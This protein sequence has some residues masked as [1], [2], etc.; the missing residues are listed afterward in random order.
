MDTIPLVILKKIFAHLPR[1]TLE[2]VI[3]NVC[4]SWEDVAQL[5]LSENVV[6]SQFDGPPPGFRD[7][8]NLRKTVSLQISSGWTCKWWEQAGLKRTYFID[9]LKQLNPVCLTDLIIPIRATDVMETVGTFYSL[10]SLRIDL[11]NPRA[12][13]ICLPE[14]LRLRHLQSLQLDGLA[15]LSAIDL[16]QITSATVLTE[17]SFPKGTQWARRKLLRVI[18]DSYIRTIHPWAYI[19]DPE[20]SDASFGEGQLYSLLINVLNEITDLKN[21]QIFLGD[22]T[23]RNSPAAK[24]SQQKDFSKIMESLSRQTCLKQLSFGRHETSFKL[25]PGLISGGIR[26]VRDS[27][28]E[29]G[30]HAGVTRREETVQI[31]DIIEELANCKKLDAVSMSGSIYGDFGRILSA[32]DLKCLKIEIDMINEFV[33]HH[34][35]KL[36]KVTSLEKL[37][38][39]DYAGT[40]MDDKCKF[41]ILSVLRNLAPKLLHLEMK[42]GWV[43]SSIVMD[44]PPMKNLEVL[45][46]VPSQSRHLGQRV[47]TEHVLDFVT[48]CPNLLRPSFLRYPEQLTNLANEGV[49][50]PNHSWRVYGLIEDQI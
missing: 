50:Q 32:S 30:L 39:G 36:I 24:I 25:N 28:R 15:P 9:F 47:L 10:Q 3:V 5:I 37:T 38:L 34:L 41:I 40:P 27:L 1:R 2:D 14:I 22:F 33:E 44:L 8:R 49:G 35:N 46:I 20:D 19:G 16:Q 6:V 17:I 45:R 48:R 12:E 11:L 43:D 18:R 4:S 31:E 42:G 29:F 23:P 21:V 7:A 26:C 13:S